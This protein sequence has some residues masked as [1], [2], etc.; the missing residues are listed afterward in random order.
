[1]EKIIGQRFREEK[2]PQIETENLVSYVKKSKNKMAYGWRHVW[3]PILLPQNRFNS[4]LID[5]DKKLEKQ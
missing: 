1:M 5:D 3:N 2:K 4:F